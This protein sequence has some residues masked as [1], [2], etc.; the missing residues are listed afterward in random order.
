MNAVDTSVFRSRKALEALA[1]AAVGTSLAAATGAVFCKIFGGDGA[2]GLVAALPTLLLGTLWAKLLRSPRTV[3]G[4]TIRLGWLLSV[5]LAAANAALA[6]G[7]LFASGESGG[8]AITNF[9]LGMLMGATIGAYFWIPGLLLTLL[10]FG[11]PIARGQRLARQGLAGQERGDG[12]VGGASAFIATFALLSVLVTGRTNVGA[13]TVAAL[14]GAGGLIGVAV[15]ALA[16]LRDRMRRAFVA[17]VEAGE[18]PQFRV[19]ESDEGKVLVRIVSQA[20]GYR[21]ADFVE[22]VAALDRDGAVTRARG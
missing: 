10:L 9:F 11:V 17:Q 6:A 2:I 7:L 15:M 8:K 3:A 4:T 14:G 13:W 1:T 12:F 21:V 22:E 19:D 16:W 18:V 5:P 20:E